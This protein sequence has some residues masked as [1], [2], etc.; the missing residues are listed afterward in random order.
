VYLHPGSPLV[1]GASHITTF[2]ADAKLA[3][4]LQR[5][6]VFADVAVDGH[7]ATRGVTRSDSTRGRSACWRKEAT[8]GG[9]PR[10][11]ARC[12]LDCAGAVGKRRDGSMRGRATTRVVT[13]RFRVRGDVP[14]RGAKRPPTLLS[15]R[16]RI[17]TADE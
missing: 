8:A 14:A 7:W 6:P 16:H 3:R 4:S 15:T 12:R 13:G 1:R 17:G 11:P 10:L 2:L 9:S 5:E